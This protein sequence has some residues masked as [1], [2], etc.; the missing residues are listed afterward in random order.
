MRN[1]PIDDAHDIFTAMPVS[2]PTNTNT[3]R[4]PSPPPPTYPPNDNPTMITTTHDNN[5]LDDVW[6]SDDNETTSHSTPHTSSSTAHP[7][8]IPRLRQE[9]TTAGYRD[10]ISTA[11]GTS[12]Q[13]GFDEGFGLGATIGLRAG[14][15]AG[16]LE[17]LVNAVL[18]RPSLQS[19]SEE[20]AGRMKG[21]LEEARKDLS[22]QS[23]FGSEYW[24]GDGTWKYEVGHPE[25]EEGTV[26]SDVAMAHPLLKK[27][28]GIVK[29]EAERYGID[30][31][32]LRDEAA[33]ERRREEGVKGEV[34]E[35]RAKGTTALEW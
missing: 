8:D 11:K 2:A 10:G 1:I 17:G 7:S 34:K 23:V 5:H 29:G 35:V 3:N 25:G 18:S 16:V 13:A 15:L 30:W 4:S 32:V 12:V 21:L 20:T 27:W 9:H 33:E 24:E 28:D 31:D 26:F 14:E 19:S 6:G 22:V